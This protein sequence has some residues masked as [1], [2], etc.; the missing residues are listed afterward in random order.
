MRINR[1]TVGSKVI[2]HLTPTQIALLRHV[3]EKIKAEPDLY[4][5]GTWATQCAL[6]DPGR[7][8]DCGTACCIAGHLVQEDPSFKGFLY[9]MGSPNAY[10]FRDKRG[11]EQNIMGFA[12]T[13]LQGVESVFTLFS[14]A[15]E[16]SWPEPFRSQW[17]RAVT[18]RMKAVVACA[19]IDH[20]IATGSATGQAAE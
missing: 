11:V 5:Q 3:Q 8:V 20:V 12:A 17:I 13:M 9:N 15:P 1:R 16:D 2:T 14:G 10:T 18:P 7:R 19:M 4:D 6:P